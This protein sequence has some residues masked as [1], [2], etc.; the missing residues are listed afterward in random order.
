MRARFVVLLQYQCICLYRW[1]QDNHI[2]VDNIK[3]LW[4]NM[5]LWLFSC[6]WAMAKQSKEQVLQTYIF[7]HTEVDVNFTIKINQASLLILRQSFFSDIEFQTLSASISFYRPLHDDGFYYFITFFAPP[8]DFSIAFL[9]HIADWLDHF[10]FSW[11]VVHVFH[12][13][14]HRLEVINNGQSSVGY[15][16][17]H[18]H[19]LVVLFKGCR[20]SVCFFYFLFTILRNYVVCIE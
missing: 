15:M 4:R 20:I 13:R 5:Y 14:Y 17:Y 8:C 2:T 12:K 19:F 10:S 9:Y 3:R 6:T 1:G 7:L 11:L 18:V 16:N